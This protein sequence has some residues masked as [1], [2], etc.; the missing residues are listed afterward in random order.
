MFE[1]IPI[2]R[3]M[4][5]MAGFDPFRE[6]EEMERS[7]FGGAASA[8]A[9]FRTDVSD[10]GEAYKLEC[11]L[12]G[13]KKED[14]Q[15]DI[16]NDCLTI[17]AE[18]RQSDEEKNTN[19]IK[20]ERVYGSFSRSFDVSGIEVDGINAS[21]NDGILTLHMPKRAELMPVSRKLEIQ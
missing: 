5:R 10:M 2:D 19:Y 16:E 12:P 11:E 8:M 14:I 20:R 18:R 6:F 3:H 15:I 1:L 4:R 21:Y 7:F 9:G 17:T 13:F